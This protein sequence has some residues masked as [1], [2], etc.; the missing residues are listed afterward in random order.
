MESSRPNMENRIRFITILGHSLC[1]IYML[2][3]AAALLSIQKSFTISLTEL[4]AIGTMSY[5]IFGVGALPSGYLATRTNAKLTLKLFF[6]LSGLSSLFIGLTH[7]IL[8]F[9]FGLILLGLFSSLYHVSGLTLISQGIRKKGKSM[10]I[11]G[12][13]GS[14]GIA[15]TPLLSGLIL[16][17]SGWRTIYLIMAVPGILGYLFLISDNQIPEAHIVTPVKDSQQV[18][19][20]LATSLF[21]LALAAMGINGFIYRGFLTVLPAYIAK[22]FAAES[23]RAQLT[24]GLIT[25]IILSVGMVG[26][27]IGGH[28]SDRIRLTKLYLFFLVLSVPFMFLIG[29]STHILI[30]FSAIL[31]SLFHFPGQPI[32]NHLISILIPSKWISSAYGLKFIFTFGVGSFATAFVGYIIDRSAMNS[33]FIYLGLILLFSTFIV[34]VMTLLDQRNR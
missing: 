17:V 18:N 12:M 6:L 25:T 24:G 15:L 16:S 34:S 7:Q 33:V 32:E 19:R 30:F 22:T 23:G 1:H 28:L 9:T 8:P 31:F 2:I 4:T 14:L 13:A 3:F 5:L 21:L 11:H 29:I 26:Q 27:Y 20:R 10:G